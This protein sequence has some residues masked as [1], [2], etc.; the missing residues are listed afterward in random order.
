MKKIALR[1]ALLFLSCVGGT[2]ALAQVPNRPP[3]VGDSVQSV[4]VS[5]DNRVTFSIY[6]PKAS[7]VTISGDFRMGAPPA[8]L[9]KNQEGVWSFTS[10][11]LP[12]DS[13]T[14]NFSVDGL[15]V[16]DTKNPT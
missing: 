16:L 12:P 9:T 1:A 2:G 5:A 15:M 10:D 13:Y 7:T 8:D 6:A 11:P 3:S 4:K 14:Y